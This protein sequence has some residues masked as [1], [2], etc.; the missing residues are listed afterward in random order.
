MTPRQHREPHQVRCRGLPRAV[1]RASARPYLAALLARAGDDGFRRR[2]RGAWRPIAP[3]A[4]RSH[5]SNAR[6]PRATTTVIARA[7]QQE[8]ALRARRP[9]RGAARSLCA[10]ATCSCASRRP[11]DRAQALRDDLVARLPLRR[12]T[13]GHGRCRRAQASTRRATR[14]PSPWAAQVGRARIPTRVR[15]S[16]RAIQLYNREFTYTLEP[17]LLD[18]RDP[19][20]DFLFDSKRASAS[21]TRAASRCSCAPRA[22]PRAW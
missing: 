19:Y 17:P 14:A 6:A 12:A 13:A 2:R 20:D 3:D 11:V 8:L 7:A 9:G 16:S 18:P 5:Y 10:A 21:T 15:S 1:R 4:A 22:F